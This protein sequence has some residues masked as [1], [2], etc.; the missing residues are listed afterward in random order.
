MATININKLSVLWTDGSM[1]SDD[2]L[3]TNSVL[4]SQIQQNIYCIAS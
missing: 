3:L 1:L 2:E 4:L